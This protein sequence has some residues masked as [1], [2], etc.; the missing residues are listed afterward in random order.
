M[1][2]HSLVLYGTNMGDSN[3]HLHYDVPFG[4]ENESCGLSSMCGR[5][6]KRLLFCK[7]ELRTNFSIKSRQTTS[8]PTVMWCTYVLAGLRLPSSLYAACR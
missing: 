1:L 3:Q 6:R 2:D 4:P 8:G 7:A 5:R